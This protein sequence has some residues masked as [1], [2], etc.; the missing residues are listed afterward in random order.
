PLLQIDVDGR[1]RTTLP[2]AGII[3]VLR[4]LVEAELLIV[5]GAD[6][7]GGVDRALLQ[8]RI[9]VAAGDLLSDAAQPV[10]HQTGDTGDA[11]FQSLEIVDRPDLLA[12]PAPHLCTGGAADDAVNVVA[13]VE[14]GEQL[15]PAAPVYP[16]ILLARIGAERNGSIE[17][18]G[19]V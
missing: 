8:C 5:V 18:E 13:L 16:G 7:L 1:L 12:E 6:P 3:V 19:R 15:A 11:E 9:D 4:D 14:L 10:D 2:P 17:G